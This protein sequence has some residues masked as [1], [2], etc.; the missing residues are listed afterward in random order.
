MSRTK[1]HDSMFCSICR[2][3]KL[4]IEVT[5][6]VFPSIKHATAKV[7]KCSCLCQPAVISCS[8]ANLLCDLV[9]TYH[10]TFSPLVVCDFCPRAYHLF[11]AKLEWRDLPLGE[12]ACPRCL[13]QDSRPCSERQRKKAKQST[14]QELLLKAAVG[15]ARPVPPP[16][17]L[18]VHMLPLL[19]PGCLLEIKVD[20]CLVAGT[21][22]WAPAVV[23]SRRCWGPPVNPGIKE[24]LSCL[25]TQHKDS[26]HLGVRKLLAAHAYL[27]GCGLHVEPP[28]DT[29][30]ADVVLLGVQN[31]TQV[32]SKDA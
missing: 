13:Q 5:L 22:A 18:A 14:Q 10:H 29:V 3:Y 19:R 4:S 6:Y 23:V 25:K 7:N 12:W 20:S 1:H 2:T 30:V 28:N 9:Q 21:P 11:C 32:C 26:R 8:L 24:I 17:A 27:G 15:T 16:A 31:E